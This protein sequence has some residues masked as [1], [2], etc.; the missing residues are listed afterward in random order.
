MERSRNAAAR[1]TDRVRREMTPLGHSARTGSD[2]DPFGIICGNECNSAERLL[3][4]DSLGPL[5]LICIGPEKCSMLQKL[6]D[7]IKAC[8]K[9]ASDAERRAAEVADPDLKADYLALA[10]QWIHL[11]RSYEFSESLERFLL[12]SQRSKDAQRPRPPETE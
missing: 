5:F 9:R 11:A 8:L 6:E 7:H 10:A 4:L 1:K 3:T 12:D 2:Y